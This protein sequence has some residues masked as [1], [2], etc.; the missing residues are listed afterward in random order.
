MPQQEKGDVEP[1]YYLSNKVNF[2]NLYIRYKNRSLPSRL[3]QCKSFI[4]AGWLYDFC[5]YIGSDY[6]FYLQLKRYLKNQL[7]DISISFMPPAN[8]INSLACRNLKVKS[9][10]TNHNVPKHD[11]EN[12]NRWGRN[13]VERYLRKKMVS[14][15]D[16]IHVLFEEFSNWFSKVEKDK[17]K[18]IHNYVSDHF[19]ESYGDIKKENL[20]IAVG[21]LA[22]VKNYKVLIEAFGMIWKKYPDWKVEIYGVG[23]QKKELSDLVI[24]KNL[25]NSVLLK[26]HTKNIEKELERAKFFAHPALHEGFG[27]S[28]AEALAKEL[29]VIAFSDCDGVNQFVFNGLNGIMVERDSG[30]EGYAEAMSTLISNEKQLDKLTKNSRQSVFVFNQETYYKNWQYLISSI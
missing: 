28:V 9:I 27:L 19:F 17:I 20:I 3:S 22:P 10:I 5:D 1:F 8:T 25:Q 4:P 30:S 24:E 26:G 13:R 29:P 6:D 2:I 11:Y 7:V 12:I 14:K 23:P 15:A 21:R 18:V 16:V